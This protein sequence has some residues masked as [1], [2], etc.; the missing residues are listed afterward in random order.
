MGLAWA[1]RTSGP[2]SSYTQ[3][4]T[5]PHLLILPKTVLWRQS[6]HMCESRGQAGLAFPGERPLTVQETIAGTLESALTSL[7]MCGGVA[8][9]FLFLLVAK[10]IYICPDT[11]GSCQIIELSRE[12]VWS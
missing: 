11:L 1:F 9:C 7:V 8:H 4:P 6:I 2:T 5:R 3:T 12:P 10:N